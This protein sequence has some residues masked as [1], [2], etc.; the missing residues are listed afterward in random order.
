MTTEEKAKAFDLFSNAA[1]EIIQRDDFDSAF[2]GSMLLVRKLA[3][4]DGTLMEDVKIKM[5]QNRKEYEQTTKK[6]NH[7]T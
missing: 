4:F 3:D 1:K 5:E 2:G 6:D 7:S